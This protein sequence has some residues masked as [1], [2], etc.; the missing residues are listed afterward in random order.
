MT[1]A[2][3]ALSDAASAILQQLITNCGHLVAEFVGSS[4][5]SPLFVGMRWSDS[6]T[7][8]R[9]QW[10]GSAWHVIGP[11]YENGALRTLKLFEGSISGTV[12][13]F[14]PASAARAV[15]SR[16]VLI[17]DTAT[18]GSDGSNKYTV[19]LYNVT[20]A[21]SLFS[22]VPTTNGDEL[23]ANTAWSQECDQNLDLAADD[24]LEVRITKTGSPTSLASARVIVQVDLYPR[25]A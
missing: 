24:V 11:L 10:D 12:S 17:S 13:F 21:E 6:G 4:E 15:A 1:F 5:P 19:D 16:V 8:L 25:A 14:V 3:P 22:A 20:Q 9:K 2:L 18:S 7:G 23:A